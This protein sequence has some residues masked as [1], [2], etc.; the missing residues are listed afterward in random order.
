MYG[1]NVNYIYCD[2]HFAIYTHIELL[3]YTPEINMSITSQL[4]YEVHA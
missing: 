2:N 3:H 4:E 1:N